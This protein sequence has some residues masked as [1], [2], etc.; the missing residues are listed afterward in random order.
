MNE[1]P[2]WLRSD[3]AARSRKPSGTAA[4][5]GDAQDAV[6]IPASRLRRRGPSLRANRRGCGPAAVMRLQRAAGN[7]GVAAAASR[8]SSGSRIPRS[9][10]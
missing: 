1:E 8:A 2:G 4:G 6:R 7:A 10:T 5:R 9:R 3:A